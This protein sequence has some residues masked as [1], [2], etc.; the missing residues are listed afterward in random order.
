MDSQLNDRLA[1]LATASRILA[2]HGHEDL[3]LGHVALRDPEGQGIWMKRRGHAL[4]ELRSADD[5]L[6]IDWEGNVL[7]GEGR[8]H[9][10]WPVH[11][12]PLRAR[13]DVQVSLHS[14]PH[15]ATL[16]S[17]DRDELIVVTQNGARVQAA[18]LARFDDTPDLVRTV[19][20]G[21]AVARSLGGASILLMRN[22][23][24]SVYTSD[25]RRLALLGIWL[26]EAARAHLDAAA[27]G[28]RFSRTGAEEAPQVVAMPDAFYADNWEYLVRDLARAESG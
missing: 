8:R 1:E 13:P 16:L 23:G 2:R 9:S 7:A 26:E 22:H 5:F 4:S 20:E 14:H 10:E 19:E 24:V 17:G 28:R 21:E 18:G 12:M 11:A 3:T 27:S 25:A 6:L 15:H